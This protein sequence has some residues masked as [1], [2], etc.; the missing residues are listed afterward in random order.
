V[1]DGAENGR[2]GLPREIEGRGAIRLP[3]EAEIV[4]EPEI[5]PRGGRRRPRAE[6]QE[7]ADEEGEPPRAARA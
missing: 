5:D 1:D 6:R 7:C 4:D 3:T 2:V